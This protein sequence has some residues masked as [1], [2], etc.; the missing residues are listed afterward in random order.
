MK[1]QLSN[2]RRLE[3]EKLSS[4]ACDIFHSIYGENF[5]LI[6]W[7]KFLANLYKTAKKSSKSEWLNNCQEMVLNLTR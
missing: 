5:N 2:K 6:E 3:V 1:T 7:N 4:K